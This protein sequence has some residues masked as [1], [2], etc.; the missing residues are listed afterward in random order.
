MKFLLC[1]LYLIMSCLLLRSVQVSSFGAATMIWSRRRH[2]TV[3]RRLA[4]CIDIYN[5]Q[6]ELPIHQDELH[7]TISKIKNYLGYPT[8]SIQVILV[9]DEVMQQRNF[10]TRGINKP[11]DILSFPFINHVTPGILEKPQFDIPD[12]YNLGDIIVNVPYVMRRCQEDYDYFEGDEGSNDS[13]TDD[14]E[15]SDSR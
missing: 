6:D 4:S 3:A 2:V 14:D 8:H 9:T 5:E 12:Y 1:L 13:E 11:T 15:L 7:D 10:E